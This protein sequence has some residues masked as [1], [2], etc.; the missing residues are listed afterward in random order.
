ML[1]KNP[2]LPGFNPDPCICR[3]GDD[4]FIAVSSFEWF[5]G[6][7]IYHSRDMKHWELYAHALTNENTCDLK[8]LPSAKGIWAPC[9]T[10]CE[11]DGLFYVVYGMMNSMN[12]RYFDVDNFVITAKDLRGPWSEPVYLHSAGFDASMLHDTDGRKWVVSLDWETRTGYE[13]PG[14]ICLVEYDPEA[15]AIIGY[16]KRIWRGATERGCLEAPHLTKRGDWYYLMCA[17][18]GTGYYHCVTMAR[19]KSVWGPYEADP[20]NPILTAVPENN[21]ERSNTDHLKPRYYNPDTSLQKCGHGSYVE[22]SLGETYLV[23]LCARPFAP[24]LRCTLGRET[25]MQKMAWTEDGWLRLAVCGNL[26]QEYVEGCALPD[27]KAAGLPELDDFDN[28]T[29]GLQYYA[30]RIDPKSFTDLKSRPGWL[31][32]RGQEARSS[33][34]RVSLL[35]RKL[36]SVNAVIETKMEFFPDIY[37]HSAGLILYYDNMN[38]IYLRKYYSEGLGAPAVSVVHLRN[39]NKT[40]YD[41]R[42]P[43]E[44]GPLWFRLRIEGRRSQFSW[45][46]DEKDWQEIGPTFDTS[47]FSDEFSEYGEFTG[48]FVGLTCADRVKH[49][50]CADF[51]FFRYRDLM[52]ELLTNKNGYEHDEEEPEGVIREVRRRYQSIVYELHAGDN[53]H[54]S[55]EQEKREQVCIRN[56]DLQGLRASI[57][58]A[59]ME[60]N[61]VLAK[62]PL[63]DCKNLAVVVF[64]LASR[65]AIEGGLSPE[66]AFSMVDAFVQ[67]AEDLES[68]REVLSLIRK[69]EEE[70]C[71]AVRR[72]HDK[73]S[74]NP[75]VVR[76]RDLVARRLH[77]QIRLTELADEMGINANYLSQLFSRE[78]GMSLTDYI[79][80][81][82]VRTAAQ[83]LI[84]TS[85]SY[86]EIAATMGF[87]SQSHFGKVFKKWTGMT[88]KQ[89]RAAYGEKR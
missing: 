10:Y 48:T 16:P 86:G 38:Y 74:M 39:G 28:E 62:D 55:Y 41:T 75:L 64:T 57:A 54:N 37:Q 23:H 89:Y 45:S 43:V 15:K 27:W 65:S 11:A 46:A 5:P 30:P 49:E 42:T 52:P 60:N 19:S 8:R 67:R 20:K 87:S 6:I 1:L 18:G 2:I 34:N 79:A 13:K 78:Q 22:T 32:M 58:E 61:G 80:R 88:P 85:E 4:Y 56:G 12:A 33:T 81:E 47:E 50:K 35:A 3:K 72:L 59:D 17:E 66:I 73:G 53:S 40:D 31:R 36:T 71:L 76:C 51:D 26:A 14:A 29:L 68:S 82:K 63:R 77:T 44:D 21:D 70:F 9:L 69:G 84:F 24:E 7:P 25:A 83:Q